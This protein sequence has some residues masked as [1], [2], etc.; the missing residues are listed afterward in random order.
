MI[1]EQVDVIVRFHDFRRLN[2][3]DRCIFSLVGQNYRPLSIV[4]VL[5]RFSEAQVAATREALASHLSFPRAPQLTI[6]NLEDPTP[7]DARTVLLNKGLEAATGRYIAFLDYDDLLY[8]EAYSLIVSRLRATDAAV[9]F[10]SVRVVSV[11]VFSQFLYS[12]RIVKESFGNGKCL[13]DLFRDNFCPVHS[14][15]LDR[16]RITPRDLVFD[17]GSTLEEGYDLLLRICAKYSSD[18]LLIGTIIGDYYW[19]TNDSDMPLRNGMRSS[20]EPSGY[21]KIAA[22]MEARRRTTYVSPQVQKDAG[23]RYPKKTITI[24]EFIEMMG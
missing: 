5:Q 1:T 11:Q 21:D 7:K 24:R 10:A 13:V 15:V 12:R 19:K 18:F 22:R 17:A 23:V 4:L 3:L 9:V 6:L 16:G 14:F 20:V 2:E 8:P